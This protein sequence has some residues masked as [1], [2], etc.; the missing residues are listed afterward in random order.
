MGRGGA[1]Y[2]LCNFAS[3]WTRLR[4]LVPSHSYQKQSRNR[5]KDPMQV[6]FLCLAGF[7]KTHTLIF[8]IQS[9]KSKDNCTYKFLTWWPVGKPEKSKLQGTWDL[10]PNFALTPLLQEPKKSKPDVCEWS[11]SE[12]SSLWTTL[13]YLSLAWRSDRLTVKDQDFRNKWLI[14]YRSFKW[15]LRWQHGVYHKR[16]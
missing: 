7:S 12:F 3:A 14:D 6:D 8:E 5:K 10:W 1:A 13:I 16:L 9:F 4:N 2:S 15:N 11:L